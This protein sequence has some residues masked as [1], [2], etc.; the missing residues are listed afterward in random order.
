M[1][2]RTRGYRL[3]LGLLTFGMLAGAALTAG[4]AQAT[5]GP[6]PFYAEPAWD[7]KLG[8]PTIANCPRFLVLTNWNSE[9]VLDKE[10]GLVWERSPALTT[11]TWSAARFECTARTTGNRKG[12]RLPSIHELA[13]LIF[14]S[15]APP[16]PTLP[17]GHPFTNVQP[18]TYWSASTNADFPAN[19]LS[20]SFDSGFVA[21]FDNK[22]SSFQVWCARGG[23]NADAY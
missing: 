10:T 12:W 11:H 9:A 20:V 15:V 3:I 22:T 5:S 1:R 7:Q 6:G 14:P 17:P 21:G 19:A 8:C 4:P 2:P 13:S 23:N 18:V 16:G